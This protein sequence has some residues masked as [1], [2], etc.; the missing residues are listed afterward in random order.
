[1]YSLLRCDFRPN[2]AG[3]TPLHPIKHCW[4][5]RAIPKYWFTIDFYQ[6]VVMKRGLSNIVLRRDEEAADRRLKLWLL[7]KYFWQ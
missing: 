2:N 4:L 6:G 5:Y 7:F 1:M 3:I